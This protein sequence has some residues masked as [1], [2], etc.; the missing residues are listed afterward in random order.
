[1]ETN[2]TV[3]TIR[4]ALLYKGKFLVL[5]KDVNSKN[6]SAIEFPGGKISKTGNKHSTL[7]EQKNAVIIEVRE[8]TKIDVKNLKIHKVE[9]Y[10]IFFEVMKNN[11]K[12]KYKRLV[13][14]FLIIISDREI[15]TVKVNETINEKG[16]SED[17]HIDFKWI[18]PEEL[19]ESCTKLT[20]NKTTGERFYSLSRNSRRIKKL[21]QIIN[22]CK[23]KKQN[24]MENKI[25]V[26]QASE[27]DIESCIVIRLLALGS[28]D[29]GRLAGDLQE[30]SKRTREEWRKFFFGENIITLLALD[31]LKPIGIA[32]P[33]RNKRGGWEITSVFIEKEYR[34]RVFIKMFHFGIEEIKKRGGKIVRITT[35]K[36][37]RNVII[38]AKWFGFKK[39]NKIKQFFLT[40]K[41]YRKYFPWCIIMELSI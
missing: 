5:E 6:P 34:G 21:L 18:S 10:E 33:K 11:L 28:S 16:E 24:C 27:E 39:V 3:E 22:Y 1:M 36:N 4:V 23:I 25:R 13:H 29:G 37:N 26:V 15:V 40:N 41:G 30:E 19:I 12:K 7:E 38:P 9:E 32:I 31:D 35:G 14:L 20:I 8:E 2:L 17:K